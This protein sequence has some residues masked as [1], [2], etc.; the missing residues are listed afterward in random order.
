[1]KDLFRMWAVQSFR[2]GYE[3]LYR[4]HCNLSLQTSFSSISAMCIIFSLKLK[5]EKKFEIIDVN[6]LFVFQLHSFPIF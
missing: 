4:G 2:S 1:M 3:Y 5:K 6:D